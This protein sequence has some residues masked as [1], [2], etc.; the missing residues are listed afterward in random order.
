VNQKEDKQNTL[1]NK[2]NKI[3]TYEDISVCGFWCYIWRI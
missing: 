2:Q 3:N 1:E